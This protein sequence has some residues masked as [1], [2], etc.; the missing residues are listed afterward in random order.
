M[1]LLSSTNKATAEQS[2]LRSMLSAVA[3]KNDTRDGLCII[4][5]KQSIKR[6]KCYTLNIT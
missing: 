6:K 1:D 5:A 3:D 2:W 4:E